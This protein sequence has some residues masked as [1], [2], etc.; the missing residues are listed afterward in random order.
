V[1]ENSLLTQGNQGPGYWMLDRCPGCGHGYL[2]TVSDG[3]RTNLLCRAC[4]RCWAVGMG[5]VHQIDPRTCPG[6]EWR[7]TCEARWDRPT[8]LEAASST[9]AS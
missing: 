8:P 6:C 5:W 1:K 7:T 9:A 3:T 4:S 2:Y